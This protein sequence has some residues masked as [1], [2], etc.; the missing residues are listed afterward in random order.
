MFTLLI[1][2]GSQ[3]AMAD[4]EKRMSQ[5]PVQEMAEILMNLNHYPSPSEKETLRGIADSS[6]SDVERIL[7]TSILNMRH[8]INA[9]DKEKLSQVI[10]DQ[11]APQNIRDMANIVI[12]INHKPSATDM[13]QLGQ[14][15]E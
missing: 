3:F 11:S 12:N 8:K 2:F 6:A 14:I 15:L 10:N 1:F 4:S 9:E 13:E 5:Q 7:A